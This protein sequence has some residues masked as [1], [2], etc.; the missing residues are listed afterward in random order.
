MLRTL[1]GYLRLMRIHNCLIAFFSIIVTAFI[2]SRSF[3]VRPG[4]LLG[5]VVTLFIMAG[6]NALNDYCDD[7]IDRLN[8][9]GRP[10]PSGLIA[11]K[12]ALIF[13]AALFFIGLL[14]SLFLNLLAMSIVI[15]NTCLLTVYARNSKRMFFAANLLV[16]LMTSSVFIFSGAIVKTMNLDII[17]LASSAFF[18]MTSREI[19]KDIEDVQ[20]DRRSGALTIPIKLGVKR[21]RTVST[22]LILPAI[23][24]VFLP[25]ILKRMD[26]PSLGLIIL[27]TMALIYSLFLEPKKSQKVIKLATVIVLTAFLVG[28]F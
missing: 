27:A 21:A 7:E 4:V 26:R 23:P 17:V 11:P 13:S 5:A 9:P 3:T 14:L 28:S 20:G 12:S 18:V 15:V 24:L 19:L 2:A 25:W 10:V 6:G 22:I 1:I 16:A 8:K